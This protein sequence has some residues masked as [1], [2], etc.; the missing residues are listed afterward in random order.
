MRGSI[1]RLLADSSGC[2]LEDNS[3]LPPIGGALK[4]AFDFAVVTVALIVLM[5][6]IVLTAILVRLLTK[7]SVILCER[8]IG[9]GGKIFVGYKF[10]LPLERGVLA[11]NVA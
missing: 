9:Y 2:L 4:R 10:R 7:K 3:R 1:T 8:Y 6:L 5:P 11:S